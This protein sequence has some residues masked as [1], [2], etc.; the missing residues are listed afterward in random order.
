MSMSI[1]SFADKDASDAKK[2][3]TSSSEG[4]T[5]ELESDEWLE[6][7]VVLLRESTCS[8]EDDDGKENKL[9]EL[10]GEWDGEGDT[11]GE[12]AI[13]LWLFFLPMKLIFLTGAYGT[14]LT[15]FGITQ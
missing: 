14:S 15:L 9:V 1:A 7:A 10:D 8:L 6:L 13:I 2:L 4:G 5:N 12:D 3:L 11:E